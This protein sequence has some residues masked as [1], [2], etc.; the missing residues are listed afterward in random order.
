MRKKAFFI[1]STGQ[2]V[3]KT[4]ICL[5]LVSGLKK[6]F[7]K[8][9]FLKPIGQEHVETDNGVIVDKDVLLFKDY[10]HLEDPYEIMSPILF[11]KGFTRDYLDGK[12]QRQHLVQCLDVCY[13]ELLDHNDCVVIEGTGHVGVGTI[14][15]FNN[16]QVAAHLDVKMI[17]IAS[18]GLGS[19]FDALALN[20]EMC[21]RYKVPIAGVILNK[22]LDDK[23]EMI[24]DYMG[25][26]LSRW[27]IP[28]LG[29]IPYDAFLT[30]PTMADYAS[31]F[32][33]TLLS[34]QEHHLRHFKHIRLVATSLEVYKTLIAPSQLLITPASREDII[35]ATLSHHWDLQSIG[36]GDEFASGMILTGNPPPRAALIEELKKANIPAFYAPIHTFN[37]MKL[38]YS[39]TA[40]LRKEDTARVKEAIDLVESHIH[41]NKL[42]K[43]VSI[44]SPS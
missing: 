5:G 7:S 8:V 17:M 36:K 16:A 29:C 15:E 24:L 33:A 11:S 14:A 19:S 23:R 31:L 39:Y 20:K 12:I 28:I 9:G 40:K 35:L 42:L 18:G 21:D 2:H 13:Q 6:R 37:A 34:G 44:E 25:K 32:D 30:N 1:S 10:F 22:V 43:A 4:T 26:A 3:G 38:I 27:N 41:F